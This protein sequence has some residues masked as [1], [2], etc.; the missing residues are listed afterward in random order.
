MHDW[1]CRKCRYHR[2]LYVSLKKKTCKETFKLEHHR[3]LGWNISTP[4]Y[5]HLQPRTFRNLLCY[6]ACVL[7]EVKIKR[8]VL[9]W[10]PASL[11]R[12]HWPWTYFVLQ[13]RLA[14]M[15]SWFKLLT[16]TKEIWGAVMPSYM[17]NHPEERGFAGRQRITHAHDKRD[18]EVFFGRVECIS[19]TKYTSYK[20]FPFCYF[21]CF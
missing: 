4:T 12:N 14:G 17:H 10:D 19:W 21:I 13:W 18:E 1:P 20:E 5:L 11:I 15:Q 16:Q 7:G 8:R 6:P 2:M 9:C 3:K